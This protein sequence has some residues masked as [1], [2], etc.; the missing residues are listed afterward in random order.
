MDP[1]STGI[2]NVATI[3]LIGFLL[4]IGVIVWWNERNGIQKLVIGAITCFVAVILLAPYWKEV[5]ALILAIVALVAI[6]YFVAR[7]ASSNY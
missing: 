2:T 1:I 4:V 3:L 7:K 6:V 5:L